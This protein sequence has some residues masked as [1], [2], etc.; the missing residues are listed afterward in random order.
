M[1]GHA[2]G[3]WSMPP[4]IVDEDS[5]RSSVLNSRSTTVLTGGHSSGWCWIQIPTCELAGPPSH[6]CASALRETSVFH[7]QF[8][9]W[10]SFTRY[11]R[12]CWLSL[13]VGFIVILNH[14]L[15]LVNKA[16]FQFSLWSVNQFGVA[17]ESHG[18]K[19]M[20]D[21]SFTR[22]ISL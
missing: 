5:Y 2:L 12:I 7:I 14:L 19:A 16:N 10:Y 13:E 20:N 8:L 17:Y 11:I 18:L 3:T 15:T 9:L 22:R 1:S 6:D 4:V 21:I